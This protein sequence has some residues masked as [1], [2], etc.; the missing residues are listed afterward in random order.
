V[1]G[2]RH[3]FLAARRE[4]REG[5]RARAYRIGTAVQVAII[6]GI[7][8]IV[9]ITGG[10]GEDEF[11][12]GVVGSAADAVVSEARAQ[13]AGF[14]ATIQVE[15]FEDASAARAAIEDDEIDIAIVGGELLAPSDPPSALVGL[16][17]S[18][19]REVRGSEVLRR[20]GLSSERI[21]A[22]LEPPPLPVNEVDGGG[23][24]TGVAVVASL[25]L[26]VALIGAG[27]Y[28]TNGVVEEKST[29]VIEVV[30]SAIKPWQLLAGKVIGIGLLSLA[31]VIVVGG[32]GLIA[33]FAA[34]QIDL[35]SATAYSAALA[36]VY[37]I[38][39]YALYACGFAIGGALVSRS[40]DAGA[41]A[42][43]FMVL[44]AAY[45]ASTSVTSEPSSTLAQ[46]LTFIP[47]AAPM[48]VPARAA[49]DA[50]PAGELIVSLV[51]MAVSVVVLLRLAGRI[52]ERTVLRLGAPIRL[53][54]ALRLA[55]SP[56]RAHTAPR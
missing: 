43:I 36:A 14:D 52:Y 12:V 48:V 55:R 49:Q 28:V 18:A 35:P 45:I 46:V 10:D 22:A 16:L 1:S 19:N 47:P 20:E 25:L 32:A 38:L 26:Y 41:T 4:I 24:G 3:V 44:V 31:Q 39:G 13:Q 27:I 40:E 54:D 30:L 53:R 6:L 23:D 33:A 8:V 2:R 21:R 37:F 29:R 56:A 51:L 42:P 5:L 34:G 15:R 7:V 11:D 9:A 17:Q 50:L